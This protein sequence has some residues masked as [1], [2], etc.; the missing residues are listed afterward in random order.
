MQQHVAGQQGRKKDN[1]KEKGSKRKCNLK[2]SFDFKNFR[3]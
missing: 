1:G 3:I 2:I